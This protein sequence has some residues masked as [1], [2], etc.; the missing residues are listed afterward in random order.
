MLMSF[1]R[2]YHGSAQ[3]NGVIHGEKS[4]GVKSDEIISVVSL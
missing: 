3:A 4:T 2:Y 1:L